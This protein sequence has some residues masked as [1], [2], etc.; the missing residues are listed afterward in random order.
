MS[1]ICM[2]TTSEIFHD[3]RILNEAAFLAKN[4]ELTILAKKYPGQRINHSLGFKIKLIDYHRFSSFRANIFS[5]FWALTRAAFK[6]NPD[7]Y[8][9]HDLDGLLCAFPAALFKGKILIYDAHELWSNTFPFANLRGIQWLL[10]GLE[11]I[12]MFKVKKGITVNDSIARVLSEKYRKE[13]LSLRNFP[14]AVKPQKGIRL[15]NLYPKKK[16]ILHLGAADEGRGLEQMV[17]AFQYLPKNYLLIFLGG[18]KT[19]LEIKKLAK[20]LKLTKKIKFLPQVLPGQI[21]ESIKEADLGLALTQAASLSYYYSLPNKLFQYILAGVPILG[22][23]FLEFK[24]IILAN[25]VGETVNPASPKLI[26]QKIREMLVKKKYRIYRQNLKSLVTKKDFA[27]NWAIES[28]KITEFYR[29]LN[30]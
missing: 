17:K 2:L 10:P 8:H 16:I 12:L 24:K 20:K 23:N 29:G 30:D 27:Y 15:K 1:K 9:A 18:G 22:S 11:K 5:S 6:V 14:V 7:I 19:E 26:S 21:T 4:Y 3:S 28:K 25:E 13:F